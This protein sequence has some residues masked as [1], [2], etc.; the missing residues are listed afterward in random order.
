MQIQQQKMHRARRNWVMVALSV[1]AVLLA[2]NFIQLYFSYRQHLEAIDENLEK[3]SFALLKQ[4]ESEFRATELALRFARDRMQSRADIN[5]WTA[6]EVFAEFS[7][8]MATFNQSARVASSHDL[9]WAD[10]SGVVR[11]TSYSHPTPE[12]LVTDRDY[13]NYH[14]TDS[15]PDAFYSGGMQ[16]RLTNRRVVYQTVRVNDG[17]GRFAGVIGV[18]TRIDALETFYRELQLSNGVSII[19]SQTEGR[20]SYRYPFHADHLKVDF[21]TSDYVQKVN[22]L[23]SG[24]TIMQRSP[25][26][27]HLRRAGFYWNENKHFL[28]TVTLDQGEAWERFYPQLR[29]RL[30]LTFFTVLALLISV[31]AYNRVYKRS[32]EALLLATMDELTKIPNR[33]HLD[34]RFEQEWQSLQRQQEPL[35]VLFIDID[36]FKNY[37]D[38]YGHEAGDRCL[39]RVATAI[40][41]ELKRPDDFVARYGGEEFVVLLPRNSFENTAVVAEAILKRIREEKIENLGST[42][43]PYLTVSIGYT[44]KIPSPKED[45]RKIKAQADRA[46]YSAKENGR[47]RIVGL[48]FETNSPAHIIASQQTL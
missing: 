43:G 47:D 19:L 14:K 46:L 2:S 27:G 10:A 28:A 8:I 4:A 35:G 9:F 38:Q 7:Q 22:N 20:W 18:T 3:M 41:S 48:T 39:R 36:F 12:I 15:S 45:G 23:T 24:R 32:N 31:F 29:Q 16:S 5:N 40:K 17:S 6:D 11:V 44:A 25:Y 34:D 13:F 1:V 37:N 21:F 33:R 26:D 42:I 30:W